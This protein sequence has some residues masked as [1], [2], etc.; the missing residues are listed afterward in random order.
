MSNIFNM[1]IL[2]FGNDFVGKTSIIDRYCRD[3]FPETYLQTIG[4]DFGM[5]TV[6]DEEY[7]ID[8]VL[9]FWDTAGSERF[10][11]ISRSYCLGSSGIYFIYD[12]TNRKSFED[13]DVW[14]QIVEKELGPNRVI[15]KVLVAN[16]CDDGD[17]DLYSDPRKVSKEEARNYAK[18]KGFLSFHEVSARDNRGIAEMFQETAIKVWL[19]QGFHKSYAYEK[20][21]AERAEQQRSAS[22]CII[23]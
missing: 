23:Q 17:H 15:S 16:K 11:D 14:L 18:E 3:S 2:F 10:R 9:S 20:V 4:V 1:K 6:H 12:V 5:K 21:L 13:I 7:G 22:Q 19:Q 8:M